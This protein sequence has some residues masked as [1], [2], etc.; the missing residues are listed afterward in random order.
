M[1]QFV[2]LERNLLYT[3]MT[4]GRRL[5]VLIAQRQAL[6][7]AVKNLRTERRCSGLLARL[8]TAAA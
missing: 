4:R 2:L 1:Q 5:V 3:G 6:A 7:L 8:R